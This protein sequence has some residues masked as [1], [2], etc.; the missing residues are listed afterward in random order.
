ML[1]TPFPKFQFH[2]DAPV[3]R[4]VKEADKLPQPL[5]GAADNEAVGR[6]TIL[7]TVFAVSI[8]AF[9]PPL[10]SAISITV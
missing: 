6:S 3:E 2:D 9:P 10:I 1:V 8:Q 7:T 4:S 5:A